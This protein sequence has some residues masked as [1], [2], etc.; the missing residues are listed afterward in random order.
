MLQ[1]GMKIKLPSGK[2]LVERV[3][4]FGAFITPLGRKTVTISNADGDKT[5]EFT[6]K[7]RGYYISAESQ[8]E[9]IDG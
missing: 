4:D 2:Y 1:P 3:S 9:V 6:A 8:V 5:K 7:E